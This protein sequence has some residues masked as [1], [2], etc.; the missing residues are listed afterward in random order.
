MNFP[1]LDGMVTVNQFNLLL[2]SAER[3]AAKA[4]KATDPVVSDMFDLLDDVRTT[5]I[6]LDLPD[7]ATMLDHLATVNILTAERINQ[8]KQAHIPGT[9]NPPLWPITH[10]GTETE[11]ME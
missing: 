5:H 11:P 6:L 7:V 8:I 3:V 4:L 10:F 2:T 1:V 9:N